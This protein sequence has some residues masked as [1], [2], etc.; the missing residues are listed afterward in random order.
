[1]KVG[2]DFRA[3]RGYDTPQGTARGR[4]NFATDFTRGPLDNSPSSP[5]SLGQ[6]LAAFLLGQPTSGFID[7]ND[8]QAVQSTYWSLYFHDNWRVNR[9]LTLDLGLRWEYEGPL[10]ERFNRSVRGFDTNAAQAIEGAARA[11][12]AMQPDPALPADQFRVRGGLLFAGVGD[13]PRELWD[14][15]WQNFAPRIGLAYQAREKLV[16]RG[17][18]G[19]Y[20]IALGQSVGN[21]AIQPGFS[22]STDLIPTLNNG[23]TFIAT[24]ANPF[25]NGIMAAP[26][27]SQ[28]AATFLGRAISF[29]NPEVRTPYSMNWSFNTQAL[30]PAQFLLE[31]GYVGNKSLKL[32]VNRAL[33]AIPNEYLSTS[34]TR[35]QARIDFL[36]ANV[37]NP[38][39][40]LLPGTSFNG[41]T[42]SRAQLLSPYPAFAGVT[43]Q[44]HQGYAWFHSMQIRAERRLRSGLTLQASYMLS[45]RMEATTYL[46]GGD[47]VPYRTIS[48]IDRPH[49]FTMTGLFELPF[50]RGRA[51]GGGIGTIPNL[52]VGGW[53]IAGAW[54]WQSGVPVGFGDVIFTGDLDDIPLSSDQRTVERWFNT[55]AG[56]ERRAAFQ[57]ASNLRQ[58]PLRLSGVRAGTYNS[59]DLSLLKDFNFHE[60]YR[61]QFRAE[62]YNAFNHPTGFEPPNTNP[63][64]GAFGTVTSQSAL[65]RQIQLGLKLV[66]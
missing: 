9:K 5:G 23:Q 18:F 40:G 27:P 10:T 50:G 22:Q 46:N 3:N 51:L 25:P 48:A 37:P 44:D 55:E 16:F 21:Y 64:S 49:T 36:T 7:N 2:L 35:D 39:Q 61:L 30:L 65:P 20:P 13:Q 28:G 58:F 47:P 19:V 62:F 63:T 24:L 57:R 45:K 59:T 42:I 41:A 12:Y 33:N 43:M 34:F 17:G 14:R 31:V 15:S 38:F 4:F 29:Y 1:M 66:F 26:G 8:N 11:R 6:G 52:L 32:R 53:Q 56:F 54:Q 60:Q